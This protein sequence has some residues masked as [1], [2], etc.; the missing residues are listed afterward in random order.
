M[1]YNPSHLE[2][3]NPVS[4]GKTRA[5]QLALNDGDYSPETNPIEWSTHALNVQVHGDGALIAQGV[6]AE[7]L[8]L[9]ATPHFEIGGTVH[10]VV[11]NQVAF[12]TPAERGRSSKYCTDI[13]KIIG[14][15]V[16]HV[17]GDHPE[18]IRRCSCIIFTY[19]RLQLSAMKK[20]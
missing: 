13:A 10:L 9:N 3:V 17:N 11:N 18:V 6:N 20:Q 7:C 2:A 19:Y 4:M 14:A 12:T 15:P 5:K 1:L 16:V 8:A